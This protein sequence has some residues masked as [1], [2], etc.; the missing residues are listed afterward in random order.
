MGREPPR[1]EPAI[2]AAKVRPD[3]AVAV[4]DLVLDTH[5]GPHRAC[6]AHVLTATSAA[7]SAAM[8]ASSAAVLPSRAPTAAVRSDAA[9]V[10]SVSVSG[11]PEP[12]A[13]VGVAVGLAP[14]VALRSA[15]TCAACRSRARPSRPATT[16]S[17]AAMTLS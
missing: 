11:T 12:V 17:D 7:C 15:R 6:R 3:Y 4:D 1:S 8:E 5:G 2:P 13:G 10:R 14:V 16:A 9:E